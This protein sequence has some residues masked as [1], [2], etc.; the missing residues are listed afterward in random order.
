MGTPPPV[1][2]ALACQGNTITQQMVLAGLLSFDV[3]VDL[4]RDIS[5]RTLTALKERASWNG[6]F[7]FS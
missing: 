7:A 5:I 2:L 3:A 6:P 4:S 1:Q